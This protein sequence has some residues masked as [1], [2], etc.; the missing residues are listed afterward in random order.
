MSVLFFQRQRLSLSGRL[1]DQV[2]FGAAILPRMTRIRNVEI[3]ISDIHIWI[4]NKRFLLLQG[5]DIL[6]TGTLVPHFIPFNRRSFVEL[7]VSFS[8]I[9]C[10]GHL[11]VFP[12]VKHQYDRN[13][14]V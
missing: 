8:K 12:A 13:K 3:W 7:E 11:S 2:S 5:G 6:R 10:N 4:F 9:L 1:L 14:T